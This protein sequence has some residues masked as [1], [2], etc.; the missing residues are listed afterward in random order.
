MNK[1]LHQIALSPQIRYIQCRICIAIYV[2]I[3]FHVSHRVYPYLGPDA[4]INFTKKRKL[5]RDLSETDIKFKIKCACIS[6]F[7]IHTPHD[8]KLLCKY[9][10]VTVNS[11]NQKLFLQ[12]HHAH[13]CCDL[14]FT[15]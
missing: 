10:C 3:A 12:L 15:E 9:L 2:C 11:H 8:L 4:K 6:N 7:I 5:A 14:C 13:C 1:S